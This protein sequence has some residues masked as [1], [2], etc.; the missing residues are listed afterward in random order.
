MLTELAPG[1][2]GTRS[3]MLGRCLAK[4]K[5]RRLCEAVVSTGAA[6]WEN[7]QIARPVMNA[8]AA[9]LSL[10]EAGDVSLLI[11]HDRSIEGLIGI[12]EAAW[13]AGGDLR[14]ILRY[15]TSP[16]AQAAWRM[17]CDDLPVRVSIGFRIIDVEP[18][19]EDGEP[20]LY[21]RWRLDE[22]SQ[23]LF[24]AD[25]GA[26][27]RL[28]ETVADREQF[29]AFIEAKRELSRE[30]RAAALL[31]QLGAPE[32]RAWSGAAA[33]EL[34]QELGISADELRAALARRVDGQLE[35]M[36]GQRCHNS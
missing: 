1:S 7:G 34:S 15:G 6:K 16:K 31:D 14:A 26:R 24:A 30:Q 29:S 23:V 22:V 25:P 32:W 3:A 19:E 5:R 27:L 8:A 20:I 21:T 2:P 13:F 12:V 18:P 11:E 9:D 4:D 10:V 33:G 35:K 17:V 36:V 28:A